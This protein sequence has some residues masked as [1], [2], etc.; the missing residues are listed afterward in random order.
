MDNKIAQRFWDKLQIG[1]GCW[2]WT[3]ATKGW[4]YGSF[5]VAGKHRKANRVAWELWHGEDPGEQLVL[6]KC[7][8]PLCCRPD[9]LE[10]GDHKEN[11]RQMAERNRCNPNRGEDHPRAKL[12]A[13]DVVAIRSSKLSQR[14]LARKYGVSQGKIFQ[15]V[16]RKCWTHI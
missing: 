7:D 8:N 12:T 9:H 1:D 16:N 11:M 14:A 2:E 6:H 15:V 5:F 13:E 10:L 3:G 4:G